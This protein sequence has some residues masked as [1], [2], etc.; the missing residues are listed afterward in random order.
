MGQVVVPGRAIRFSRLPIYGKD[1]DDITGVVHRHSILEAFSAGRV[2]VTPVVAVG[3]H[4]RRARQQ[5]RFG[6]A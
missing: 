5:E 3:S 1:L 2:N 4:P 6:F